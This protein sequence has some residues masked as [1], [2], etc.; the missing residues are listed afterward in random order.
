MPF[1]EWNPQLT[2]GH[3]QIDSQHQQLVRLVNELHDAMTAGKGREMLK[4]LLERLVQYTRTHFAT[5]ESLMQQSRFAEYA[6]HKGQHE[7]LARQVLE[8]KQQFDAGSR[9]LTIDVMNFLRRWLQDH[10]LSSDRKLAAHIA[11]AATQ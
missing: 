9:H 4:P 5:E 1:I 10:I 3:P 6:E 11:A 7:T 8:F 2:I